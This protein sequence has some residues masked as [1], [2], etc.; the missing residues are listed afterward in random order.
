MVPQAVN[1][2]Y[3]YRYIC[4]CIVQVNDD[5][6][7][8]QCHDKSLQS[9]DIIQV[10]YTERKKNNFYL[11]VSGDFSIGRWSNKS[12]ECTLTIKKLTICQNCLKLHYF[13]KTITQPPPGGGPTEI[14]KNLFSIFAYI[15][16]IRVHFMFEIVFKM[17]GIFFC[18]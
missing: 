7:Y 14:S 4:F 13:L 11:P 17:R 10:D 16:N 1:S 8:C 18:F 3:R 9:I 15:S 12:I 5:C 6:D 2:Y